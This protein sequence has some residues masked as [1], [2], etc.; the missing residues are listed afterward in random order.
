M[1]LEL[2]VKHFNTR[3]LDGDEIE[4]LTGKLP[5]LYS[6]LGKYKTLDQLLGKENHAVVLYETSSKGFGHFV[7]ITKND[8]TGKVRYADSY[9]IPNPDMELQFTAYDQPLPKYL[10]HLLKGYDYESNTYDYQGKRKGVSTCGRWSSLFC[11][12]RNL[13]LRQIQE[14]MTMNRSEFLRN[15]DNIATVLTL[16]PLRDITSYLGDISRGGR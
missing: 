5:V 3:D 11:R 16:F 9:G 4:N 15:T 10:N 12:F 14:M 7:A 8:D 6:E 13:S 1:S 2:I